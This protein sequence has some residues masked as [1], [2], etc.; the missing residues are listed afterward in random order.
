MKRLI[1]Y[2]VDDTLFFANQAIGMEVDGEMQ[3]LTQ[4]EFHE[5]DVAGTLHHNLDFSKLM[6]SVDFHA[7]LKPNIFAINKLIEDIEIGDDKVI[8]VTA[9]HPMTDVVLFTRAFEKFGIDTKRVKF[10]FAGGM[11]EPH[12]SSH[13]KKALL[14]EA[15]LQQSWDEIVIYDDNVMNLKEIHALA[16]DYPHTDI[17]SYRVFSDGTIS[18]YN[19]SE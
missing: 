1:I 2:D 8:I 6:C 5:H 17:K 12:W 14:F 3:W 16:L 10:Y 18:R 15:F 4:Q 7:N 19:G 13:K 11:G 9:R